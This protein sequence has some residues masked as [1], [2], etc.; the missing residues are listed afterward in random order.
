RVSVGPPEGSLWRALGTWS[1]RPALGPGDEHANAVG[2]NAIFVDSQRCFAHVEGDRV[3]A[4]VGV[5]NLVFVSTPDVVFV[6]PLD[7]AGALKAVV[8]KLRSTRPELVNGL[9][10][11]CK[12]PG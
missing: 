11:D 6:G 3:A 12:V 8:Q 4:M 7:G 9:A 2:A 1:E 10:S 5:S